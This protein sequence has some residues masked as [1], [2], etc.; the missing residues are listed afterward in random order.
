MKRRNLLQNLFRIGAM[1]AILPRDSF[2]FDEVACSLGENQDPLFI[3][4]E[5]SGGWDPQMFCDPIGH[6]D[7]NSHYTNQ[8]DWGDLLLQSGNIQSA[9]FAV[10]NGVSIPYLCNDGEP[11]FSR[12]R[13]QLTILHGLDTQTASHR[14]GARHVW[15]GSRRSGLPSIAALFAAVAEAESTDTYPL[16]FLSGGGFDASEGLLPVSRMGSSSTL[17]DTVQPYTTAAGRTGTPYQLIHPESVDAIHAFQEHRRLRLLSGTHAPGGREALENLPNL[18]SQVDLLGGLTNYL[19]D[20]V[21]PFPT[22]SQPISRHV[23]HSAHAAVA[24]MAAGLCRSAHLT[25]N[26]FDTHDLHDDVLQPFNPHNSFGHRIHLRTLLQAVDYTVQ[27]LC[28][29]GLWHR[30]T[31]VIGSDFGRTRYNADSS[32]SI[33]GK[34]HWPITSMMVMG[35]GLQ[36]NRVVGG[37]EYQEGLDG[38]RGL[39]L[40]LDGNQLTSSTEE[41]FAFQPRHVHDALRRHL[42]IHDHPIS[43]QFNL[44]LTEEEQD[45]PILLPS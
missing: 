41:G 44:E 7:F 23:I 40:V 17:M 10:E 8:S 5:A 13:D 36:G 34:D 16:A 32:Q 37:T 30:C 9:P 39:N 22:P 35:G 20:A 15:S 43:Q 6:P 14:V 31:L 19:D 11:F 12:Y 38:A 26:G 42:G 2:G 1:G 45:L 24:A 27:L 21:S 18:W 4:F 28:Q 29:A 25:M 33:R 3:S